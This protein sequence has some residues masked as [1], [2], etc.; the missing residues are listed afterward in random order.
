MARAPC[1]RPSIRRAT[2]AGTERSGELH[3]ISRIREFD[4]IFLYVVAGLAL[5]GLIGFGV[6]SVAGGSSSPKHI[7][8]SA[9]TAPALSPQ[10][11]PP[12][13]R[14]PGRPSPHCRPCRCRRSEAREPG[15]K[16]P[17]LLAGTPLPP[18]R[19]RR[20]RLPAPGG[21]QWR[22]HRAGTRPRPLPRRHR[23]PKKLG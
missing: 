23:R 19:A 7:L 14:R 12:L 21:G 20:R 1:R 6:Y 17:R 3:V 4:R 8:P 22:R 10:P 5:V 9:S 13:H 18:P 15:A 2:A 16:H 11:A